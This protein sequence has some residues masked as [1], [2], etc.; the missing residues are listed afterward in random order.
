VPEG[1]CLIPPRG[2]LEL[3]NL[4]FTRLPKRLL[5]DLGAQPLF[6]KWPL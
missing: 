1:P 5:H 2:A 3:G 4:L 6:G